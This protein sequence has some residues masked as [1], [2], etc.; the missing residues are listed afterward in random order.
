MDTQVMNDTIELCKKKRL[1]ISIEIKLSPSDDGVLIV[2]MYDDKYMLKRMLAIDDII[3]MNST[4]SYF[5]AVIEE[6][7]KKFDARPDEVSDAIHSFLAS[8]ERSK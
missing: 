6:M 3:M 4:S 2:S 1:N 7:T 5:R 8:Q